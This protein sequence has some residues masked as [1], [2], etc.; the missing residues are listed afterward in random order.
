M[1][2]RLRHLPG[3]HFDDAHGLEIARACRGRVDFDW[4]AD[5]PDLYDDT[6]GEPT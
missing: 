4:L 3:S 6:L 1:R 5:E 2:L